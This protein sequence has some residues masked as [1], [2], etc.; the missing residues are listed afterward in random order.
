M[1]W[2]TIGQNLFFLFVGVLSAWNAWKSKQRDA[3][4]E[5]IHKAT[6]S[7]KDAL[8]EATKIASHAEGMDAQRKIDN[9][10]Q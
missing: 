1:N 5:E 2:T 4:V 10:K 9:P 6:N 3:K 7:M 8:V